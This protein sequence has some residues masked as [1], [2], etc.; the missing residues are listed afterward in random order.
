MSLV[1]RDKKIRSFMFQLV[2]QRVHKSMIY[3]HAPGIK[4]VQNE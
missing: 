2:I 1:N 4:Y 3:P